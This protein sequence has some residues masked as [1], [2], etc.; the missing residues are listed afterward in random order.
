MP[1]KF[2]HYI[3]FKKDIQK[4][5]WILLLNIGLQ[6][7][8]GW[9]SAFLYRYLPIPLYAYEGIRLFFLTLICMAI[10]LFLAKRWVPVHLPEEK[11]RCTF[12]LKTVFQ[13]LCMMIAIAYTFSIVLSW[14]ENLFHISLSESSL[15]ESTDPIYVLY[16]CL[17]TVV[18]APIFEEI[19]FRGV[20]LERLKRYDTMFAIV[21]S[22]TI[23]GLMHMNF[24]QG[25]MH[26]FTGILLAYICTKENSILL[27]ILCHM[28][29][30]GILTL[31]SY[32]HAPFL[33]MGYFILLIGMMVYGWIC[34]IP[35]FKKIQFNRI[36]Y[37]KFAWTRISIV[38]FLLVF[39]G[40]SFL[41]IRVA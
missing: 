23:F 19:L 39:V 17:S 37:T 41:N 16:T 11:F 10:S 12:S 38:L 28:L 3:D 6:L 2:T 34:L 35:Y 5:G 27:T 13:T 26:I 36:P 33:W 14:V 30:N 22:G 1:P 4:I 8:L 25:S 29:F 32:I 31:A 7:V 24:V 40:M 21:F 9:G 15:N 18:L 20:F